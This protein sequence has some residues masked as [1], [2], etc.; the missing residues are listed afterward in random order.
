M[1]RVTYCFDHPYRSSCRFLRARNFDVGKAFKL[2]KDAV[3]MRQKYEV[4]KMYENNGLMLMKHPGAQ[5]Y[6][7]DSGLRDPK[8]R[9]IGFGRLNIMVGPDMEQEPHIHAMG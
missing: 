1:T 7:C 4:A 2:F 9:P 8:G 6:A 5:M 3:A